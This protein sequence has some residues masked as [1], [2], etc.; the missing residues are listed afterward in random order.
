MNPKFLKSM[1]A[2][3]KRVLDP[4]IPRPNLFSH[5]KEIRGIKSNNEIAMKQIMD[6]QDQVRQLE[7]KVRAQNNYISA[8]NQR[9]VLKK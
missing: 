1:K 4:N 9:V 7:R 5:D 8:L 2:K 3:K 6:L